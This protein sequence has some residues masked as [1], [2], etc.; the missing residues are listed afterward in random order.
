MLGGWLGGRSFGLAGRFGQRD[1]RPDEGDEF[2]FG[3]IEE[4]L[5]ARPLRF[6]AW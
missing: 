2:A 3:A 4:A 1:A 6:N 5:Q